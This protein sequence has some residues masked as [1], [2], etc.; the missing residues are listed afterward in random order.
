MN[1]IDVIVND[2]P[3][4][5][6][7][8]EVAALL[9]VGRISVHRWIRAGRLSAVKVGRTVRI[10]RGAVRSALVEFGPPVIQE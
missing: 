9:R 6:T 2:L 10:P 7:V 8:R 5:C 4:L 1:A 3:D